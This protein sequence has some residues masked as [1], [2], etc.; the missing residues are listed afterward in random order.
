MDSSLDPLS[1]H[2]EKARSFR[3]AASALF[4]RSLDQLPFER[5][6]LLV[7]SARQGFDARGDV[8]ERRAPLDFAEEAFGGLKKVDVDL[9]MIRED[10]R[11]L[12]DATKL[13]HVAGPGAPRQVHHGAIA[14]LSI[15]RDLPQASLHDDV[16]VVSALG[17]RRDVEV[18]DVQP[19]QQI[20]PK[21]SPSRA[22]FD[23]EV[24]GGHDSCLKR[25]IL[26]GADG[27][28]AGRADRAEELRLL[29]ER[30]VADLIEEER[31]VGG[32][33]EL[34]ADPPARA[35]E[36][37]FLVSEQL[38]LEERR[39]HGR[40]V[41]RHERA[42]ASGADF[43]KGSRDELFS[44]AGLSAYQDG[45]IRSCKAWNERSKIPHGRNFADEC[46]ERA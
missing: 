13:A 26:H 4:E 1:M 24:S 10:A 18:E 42:S 36:R 16:E 39:W 15:R 38:G 22:R 35:R 8:F 6:Q 7:E 31:S 45:R 11:T 23:V 17:E 46:V 9:C 34:S 14:H 2:T 30:K 21:L 40:T 29:L 28:E 27:P 32:F 43:M 5:G 20:R 25:Q 44:G 41:D 37:A 3:L 33:L 19:V 12:E